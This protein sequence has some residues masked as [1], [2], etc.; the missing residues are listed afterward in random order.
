[1]PEPV[2][3]AGPR[4]ARFQR[5]STKPIELVGASAA[6]SRVDELVRRVAA[7]DGS[8]LLTARRGADAESIAREIHARSARRAMPFVAVACGAPDVD[9]ALF[10]EPQDH[11]ATDLEA[12]CGDCRI[13]AARGG[14]LFLEDITE[15]PA[16]VQARLARVVR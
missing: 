12:L 7:L 9:R 8:C 11:G 4:P 2:L 6:I 13:A 1:M 14:T 10:G 5:P 15:L 16:G 3:L